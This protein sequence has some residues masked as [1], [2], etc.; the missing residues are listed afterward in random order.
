MALVI[1]IL[2]VASNAS[3]RQLYGI[4]RRLVA[5]LA[6]GGDVLAFQGV[7][8]VNAMVEHGFV[9]NAGGMALLAFVAEMA[10]VPILVIVFLVA[11]YTFKRRVH[12]SAVTMAVLALEIGMT[13]FQF[14]SRLAMIKRRLFPLVLVVALVA[15]LP[16]L[17]FMNVGLAMA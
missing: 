5:R 2:A 8:A 11:G 4:E 15:F 12:I 14:E 16:K 9:P 6:L 17:A 10:L 7:V 13:E 3:F 1:V